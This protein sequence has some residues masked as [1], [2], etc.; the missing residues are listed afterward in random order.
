MKKT[1]ISI[2]ISIIPNEILIE[3]FDFFH[4]S[5][6]VNL[7]LVNKLWYSLVN[8]EYLWKKRIIENFT[9]L[10]MYPKIKNWKA[11]FFAHRNWIKNNV[12]IMFGE[13][14][15]FGIEG[16]PE[17]IDDYFYMFPS[18][19]Y[20][21]IL[22]KNFFK[23]IKCSERV[24]SSYLYWIKRIQKKSFIKFGAVPGLEKIEK[25]EKLLM[26]YK[27]SISLS[28]WKVENKD[29]TLDI[30][31]IQIDL[32]PKNYKFF[33]FKLKR[34]IELFK[35]ILK[36][37]PS[38]FCYGTKRN[39]DNVDI[40]KSV[41]NEDSTH[42]FDFIIYGGPKIRSNRDLILKILELSNNPKKFLNHDE[43]NI[44]NDKEIVLKAIGIN[45]KNIKYISKEMRKDKD[46]ALTAFREGFKDYKF[47]KRNVREDYKVA[48]VFLQRNPKEFYQLPRSLR[49]NKKIMKLVIKKLSNK[50]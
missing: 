1:K 46:V 4:L 23:T 34:N 50:K 33:N 17:Q 47:F 2:S 31:N 41:L 22:K 21:N 20:K 43:K 6:L 32:D 11:K 14:D 35:K 40:V 7:M 37:S 10:D 25:N 5:Q 30:A 3:I 15:F 29:I 28:K 19:Y 16:S 13:F 44:L 26:E 49:K 8:C 12:R 9:C 36:K 18:I 38:V 42:L 48:K 39:R 45:Q 27:R 24:I